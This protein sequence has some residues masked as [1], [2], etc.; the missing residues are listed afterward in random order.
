MECLALSNRTFEG[1]NNAYLFADGPDTVLVDT[2]DRL[3]G[4]HDQLE[5][6]LASHGVAIED[7][8]RVFLSHWHGDHRG[9]A[10][11]IQ[12]ESGA[13][14]FVHKAD[15]D[16]VR[17]ETAAWDELTD[18]QMRYFDQWGM[19][20][21]KKETVTDVLDSYAWRDNPPEVTAIEDGDTFSINEYTIRVV[22]APGH[23]AGLCLFE[24][25]D[26]S[27]NSD[28]LS[29]DALLPKY[30]PNVGGA[31][32]RVD[33]PLAQYIDTL[34]SIVTAEYD[35]AWPGHRD[36]IADPTERANVIIDH[37]EER[38][39]R[40]LDALRRLGPC[41]TWT[42]SDDLFGEL[43]HIHILHGPG[44]SYAHLE[45]LE[46]QGCIV[47]EQTEYRLTD[48]TAKRLATRDDERWPLCHD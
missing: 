4:T 16:L 12:E 6:Q 47:S 36:R 45:H 24:L 20:E 7:I 41:D 3:P 2:G 10:G 43:E 30:T 38:S 29:S 13:D 17:G 11:P 15:A 33:D 1:N 27:D 37:H 35:R 34:Q 40:V 46:Q 25:D 32:V 31:D 8:D 48:E 26:G 44:E 21:E 22:H 42:V 9:L 5:Q 14:V 23:T 28:V 18:L 39:Y 19:P